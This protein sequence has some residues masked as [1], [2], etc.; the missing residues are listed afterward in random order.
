[1][2]LL[3]DAFVVFL[4]FLLNRRYHMSTLGIVVQLLLEL[5]IKVFDETLIRLFHGALPD[6]LRILILILVRLLYLRMKC[7]W[8]DL[9]ELLFNEVWLCTDQSP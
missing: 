7:K 3:Q 4:L 6:N 1:M 5:L 2:F 8:F 9:F